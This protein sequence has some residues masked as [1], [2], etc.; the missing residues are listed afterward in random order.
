VLRKITGHWLIVAHESAVPDPATA[1][2]SL[3]QPQ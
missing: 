1:I 2:K 3:D